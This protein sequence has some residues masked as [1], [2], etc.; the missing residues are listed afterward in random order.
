MRR[1]APTQ[2]LSCPWIALAA[3]HAF[4]FPLVQ[5][6]CYQLCG[7]C[8]SHLV[9]PLLLSEGRNEVTGRMERSWSVGLAGVRWFFFSAS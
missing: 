8:Q 2:P 4:P 5:V 7:I 1:F 9:S 3:A 6:F